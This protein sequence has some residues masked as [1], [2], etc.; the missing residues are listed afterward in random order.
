M[1]VQLLWA[2]SDKLLRRIHSFPALIYDPRRVDE[3]YANNR[4][5]LLAT[6]CWGYDECARRGRNL[7][8]PTFVGGRQSEP[9]PA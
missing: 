5:P 6:L 3:L 4:F 1:V 7:G 8:F 2:E 9:K